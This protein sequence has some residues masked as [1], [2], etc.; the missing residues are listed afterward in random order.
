MI[1]YLNTEV[2]ILTLTSGFVLFVSMLLR[3]R[4][5][6]L[7]LCHTHKTHLS[8]TMATLVI[9]AALVTMAAVVIMPYFL[10]L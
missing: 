8:G 6:D 7:L 3:L 9:M 1:N 2:P 4:T 10:K 5:P